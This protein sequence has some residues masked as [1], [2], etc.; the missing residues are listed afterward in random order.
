MGWHVGVGGRA[1]GNWLL[2]SLPQQA[3]AGPAMPTSRDPG[4]G[5][6]DHPSLAFPNRWAVAA[7][8]SGGQAVSFAPAT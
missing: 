7:A 6:T 5:R 4:K 2:L 3:R 1:E 8:G